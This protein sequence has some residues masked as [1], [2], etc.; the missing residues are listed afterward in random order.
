MR[1]Y[2]PQLTLPMSPS[3]ILKTP[4]SLPMKWSPSSLT[5]SYAGMAYSNFVW[6]GEWDFAFKNLQ[7]ALYSKH[8]STTTNQSTVSN[9]NREILIIIIIASTAVSCITSV[10]Y[11]SNFATKIALIAK[12]RALYPNGSPSLI[13]SLANLL[14]SNIPSLTDRA[15]L[16]KAKRTNKWSIRKITHGILTM[17]SM[18]DGFPTTLL[19]MASSMV[20]EHLKHSLVVEAP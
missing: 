6:E 10:N 19:K 5:L 16:K 18:D 11:V 2:K 12:N 1:K 13:R 20:A 17:A 14:A 8:Y 7:V 4:P 15:N 3:W 9:S